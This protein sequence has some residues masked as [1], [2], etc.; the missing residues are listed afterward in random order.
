MGAQHYIFAHRALPQQ[1]WEGDGFLGIL[2]NPE[3]QDFLRKIWDAIP[4]TSFFQSVV[5]RRAASSPFDRLILLDPDEL[6][7]ELD[8][9][10]PRPPDGLSFQSWWL[11]GQHLVILVTMPETHEM[12]EAYFA[13]IL[14]SPKIGYLTLERA[15][16]G[17]TVFCGWQEG[18]HE[19]FGDGP[20]ATAD[21]YLRAVCRH[22][23]IPET[24]EPPTSEQMQGMSMSGTVFSGTHEPLPPEH[25]AQVQR[26]EE[27][28]REAM[29]R[30]S[31]ARSFTF[32]EAMAPGR[33]NAEDM[34]NL[35]KAE[36]LFRRIYE[37]R[38]R[39]QGVEH[40][41]ATL[42]QA[43]IANVLRLQGRA[44]EAIAV[45]ETWWLQC[46]RHRRLG[47]HET[48]VATLELALT[49]EQAG[50]VGSAEAMFEYR[51]LYFG[52]TCG[53]D[54][55]QYRQAAA[56]MRQFHVRHPAK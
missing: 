1:L 12:T 49:M 14:T 46:R 39:V 55:P 42:A 31:A 24:I 44:A 50:Q 6:P 43:A 32:G 8:S 56:E 3:N 17:G 10:E 11:G 4:T 41:E 7:P 33:L 40:F 53:M 23:R 28:A 19:N 18:R 21:E 48:L 9:D 38:L 36:A 30:V 45:C 5:A 34:A 25:A 37:T 13:A 52:L 22:L 51:T 29:A 54:S 27:E 47:H 35:A 15:M 26:W 16:Y 20:P 2:A